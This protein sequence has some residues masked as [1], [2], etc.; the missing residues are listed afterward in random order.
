METGKDK[1]QRICDTLRKETLEPA[2]QEARE[3]LE[4]ARL[5]AEEIRRDAEEERKRRLQQADQEI[6]ERKKLLHS[7]LAMACRQAVE[8]LRGKIEER[9]FNR[10]LAEVV[11]REMKNPEV[12]GSILTAVLQ[13]LETHGF[14]ESLAAVIPKQVAARSVSAFLAKGWLEMLKEKP[15]QLGDFAGGAQVKM[16]GS[17]ITV[18]LS[19]VALRELVASYVRRDFRDLIFQG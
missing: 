8:E 13:A 12:I 15:I 9:L 3:M 5:Q 4:N 14:D 2:Q 18:D 11:A 16:E 17:R 10:H 7:S 19:D 6:A 1:I